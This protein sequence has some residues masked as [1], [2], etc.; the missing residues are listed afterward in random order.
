MGKLKGASKAFNRAFGDT[1]P[2]TLKTM[3]VTVLAFD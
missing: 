1:Y 2:V 3:R